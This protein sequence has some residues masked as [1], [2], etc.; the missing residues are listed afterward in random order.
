M[1]KP[2]AGCGYYG[3]G[4]NDSRMKRRCIYLLILAIG[5]IISIGLAAVAYSYYGDRFLR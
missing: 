2:A 1:G 4:F 5:M 3:N